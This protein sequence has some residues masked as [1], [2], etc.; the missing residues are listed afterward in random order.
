MLK[1]VKAKLIQPK[2]DWQ[3]IRVAISECSFDEA[4]MLDTPEFYT[5][6]EWY[7]E[8]N[9]KIRRGDQKWRQSLKANIHIAIVNKKVIVRL[10]PYESDDTKTSDT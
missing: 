5:L 6:K 7:T 2:T 9:N 4:L 1:K 10:F 8:V 3:S